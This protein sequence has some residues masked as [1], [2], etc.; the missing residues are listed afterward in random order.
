MGTA[1]LSDLELAGGVAAIVAVALTL[2]W[3]G[4][5]VRLPPPG[6]D[7]GARLVHY[8]GRPSLLIAHFV[9]S[10]LIAVAYVPIWLGVAAHLWKVQTLEAVLAAV[11]GILYVPFALVGYSLQ[12]TVARAIAAGTSADRDRWLPVWRVV[13]FS[14]APESATGWLVVLGYA[15]WGLGAAF[16]TAGLVSKGGGLEVATAV[17]L[18]V[19]AT[20]TW[21]GAIGVVARSPRLEWGVLASG[22]AS[23]AATGLIAALL[24][25]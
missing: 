22:V 24:I 16:A 4:I 7:A 1:V 9:P 20:L 21:L 25:A 11:F 6:G 18:A 17:A 8:A 15:V 19:T 23:V 14:D 5:M 12:F 10:L 3:L 13:S 2:V